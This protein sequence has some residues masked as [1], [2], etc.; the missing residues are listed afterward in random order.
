MR[1]HQWRVLDTIEDWTTVIG[2][3]LVFILM[4]VTVVDVTGRYLFDSPLQ[5]AVEL[6]ELIL[7]MIVYLA[8]SLTQREHLHVGMDL[9][10]ERLKKGNHPLY[11]PLKAFGSI[12][13]GI[14]LGVFFYYC[15]RDFIES[16]TISETTSGPL[17]VPSW[18][19]KGV[20]CVGLLSLVVRLFVQF[21][22]SVSLIRKEG[23]K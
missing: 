3:L 10:L 12:L 15:S 5:G 1:K 13:V 4:L 11:E 18:P 9:L 17:Y 20:L 23:A 22:Q 14:V 2:G 16:I 8:I 6:S 19:V 7:I 21:F